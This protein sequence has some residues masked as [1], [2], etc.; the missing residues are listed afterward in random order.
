MS[1]LSPKFLFITAFIF[2]LLAAFLIY[3]H[4]SET[5][6][7]SAKMVQVV[8]AAVDIEPRTIVKLTMLRTVTVPADALQADAL[9]DIQAA[10]GRISKVAIKAGDQLNSY[11]VTAD[12]KE[13][14]LTALVPPD[15]RAITVGVTEVT[16]LAGLAKVGDNVDIISIING[17]TDISG[18]LIL[19]NVSVLAINR[20]ESLEDSKNKAA[21]KPATVTLAGFSAGVGETGR[22]CKPRQFAVG[23]APD[24]AH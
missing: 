12:R 2:S 22:S 24:S 9:T 15:K 4:L 7:G 16:G 18:R 8:V 20:I 11:R 5:Q 3:G 10:V 19:Q 14:G 6:N 17:D 23:A 1:K 21:E 13:I